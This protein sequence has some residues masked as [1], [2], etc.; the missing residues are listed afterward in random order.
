MV[1]DHREA[2][3]GERKLAE[4]GERVVD[5]DLALLDAFEELL[6]THRR[7]GP[8]EPSTGEERA[9]GGRNIGG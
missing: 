6:E 1:I 3:I 5:R 2:E 9:P 7:H 4:L 8:A